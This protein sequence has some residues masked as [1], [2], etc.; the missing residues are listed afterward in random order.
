MKGTRHGVLRELK[1]WLHDEQGE[2]ILWLHG[3]K[4]TGKSAIAQTFAEICFADGILG[5]SFFCSRASVRRSDIQLI[6][7]TL[8]FQLAHRYP[9]FRE[10]LL[11]LLR[12]NPDVGQES[13]DSQMEKLIVSP[14]EAAQIQTLIIIDALDECHNLHMF[15][16][17][18]SK[19]LDGIPNVK[20]FITG[21]PVDVIEATFGSPLARVFR[22]Q[23]VERSSVDADIKLCLRAW[24]RYYA[25]MAT[26]SGPPE[27]WP[28]SDCLDELCYL[29]RGCFAVAAMLAY[30]IGHTMPL[31]LDLM[32]IIRNF[33]PPIRRAHMVRMLQDVV[34]QDMT[35]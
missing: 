2:R 18:F 1:D 30:Q 35:Q 8:A 6:L 21:C 5:A 26:H 32:A 9:R 23:E 14:L 31:L 33:A 16:S 25:K 12:A 7:P 13:L 19:H 24:L 29:V 11:K 27:N 17:S 10:E 22:L 3:D 34:Q 20:F 4:E 15:L 28:S